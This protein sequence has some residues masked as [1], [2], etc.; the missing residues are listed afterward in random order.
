MGSAITLTGNKAL[1]W[2]TLWIPSRGGYGY[3]GYS[4]D[5]AH[6][7]I[8]KNAADA[9]SSITYNMPTQVEAAY[10]TVVQ[11]NTGDAYLTVSAQSGDIFGYHVPVISDI[12][13]WFE[14][15]EISS[16]VNQTV[17]NA[18]QTNITTVYTPNALGGMNITTTQNVTQ[19]AVTTSTS[20]TASGQ[21]PFTSW[22]QGL[23]G[24]ESGFEKAAGT[25][26]GIMNIIN[27]V[28][29]S[30]SL[31]LKAGETA[32]SFV[33]SKLGEL[34]NVPQSKTQETFS[35]TLTLARQAI[36]F[37]SEYGE[38]TAKNYYEDPARAMISSG[39]SLAFVGA[40]TILQS[41]KIGASE[42]ILAQ[43]TTGGNIYQ[44]ASRTAAFAMGTL[45]AE[46][47]FKEVTG[48][49]V[50]SITAQFVATNPEAK[51]IAGVEQLFKENYVGPQESVA[52]INRI[53]T[54][55][56]L[57]MVGTYYL[58]SPVQTKIASYFQTRGAEENKFPRAS[59]YDIS[60]GFPTNADITTNDLINSFNTGVITSDRLG[61]TIM[62]NARAPHTGELERIPVGTQIGAGKGTSYIYS[63]SEY[64]YLDVS[65]AVLEG[66]SEI[67]GAYFAPQRISYFTKAGNTPESIGLTS[68]IFGLYK[69]PTVYRASVESPTGITPERISKDIASGKYQT[70][71]E[72]LLEM[73]N[74]INELTGGYKIQTA[75][76][77][78][79][80]ETKWKTESGGGIEPKLRA[81][82]ETIKRGESPIKIVEKTPERFDVN[83]PLNP[84]N[85]YI[86]AWAEGN[87]ILLYNE[88]GPLREN[89]I[90]GAKPGVPIISQYGKSEWQYL[91]PPGSE[92]SK[93]VLSEYIKDEGIR[94]GV[95][96]V[97]FTGK[98]AKG[99]ASSSRFENGRLMIEEPVKYYSGVPASG[100]AASE[101]NKIPLGILSLSRSSSFSDT[102]KRIE[103]ISKEISSKVSTEVKV[104]PST[105]IS[106]LSRSVKASSIL[107]KSGGYSGS[108][109]QA[110]ESGKSVSERSSRSSDQSGKSS[111][112]S[113]LSSA[114][115]DAMSSFSDLSKES[116]SKGST[117]G[118][119]DISITGS[120][121]TSKSTTST[122][123]TTQITTEITRTRTD[124]KLPPLLPE[125]P[126]SE[127][128]WLSYRTRKYENPVVDLPYLSA[129]SNRFA[130]TIKLPDISKP[131]RGKR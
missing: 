108:S 59:G 56:I 16:T 5:T 7:T 13:S 38:L 40:G 122:D 100:S 131:R 93:P 68:D 20:T 102:S 123:I 80:K 46:S 51:G 103:S 96:D 49:S 29:A 90:K 25:G 114:M 118:S 23:I 42:S 52:A 36:P 74:P 57:P 97:E 61:E 55:D 14:P 3:G 44:L 70:I 81:T 21:T 30:L 128:R 94:I 27:P 54:M 19:T 78:I 58:A 4:I 116:T 39:I 6:G 67:S 95:R 26:Y 104:A 63:G 99:Y 75:W 119:S 32:S 1:N 126:G 18:P 115:S 87:Q 43:G 79:L 110:S 91:L 10:P 127:N 37:T 101:S 111:K 71:P 89:V 82:Y 69:I 121:K 85:Q 33:I 106:E 28:A 41:A 129:L 31:S 34:E 60:E 98:Q 12:L 53:E 47:A 83:D 22:F 35:Q 65:K 125:K 77:G 130:S 86:S 11:K 64:P 88:K 15:T 24:N 124:I 17:M 76:E 117:S 50:P 107:G 48:V 109:R 72:K 105:I 84:R 62:A 8:T 66:H 45:Y 92:T 120:S 112:S 73:E 9:V 2:D 113:D